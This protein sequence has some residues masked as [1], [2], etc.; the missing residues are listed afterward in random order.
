[1][2][3]KDFIFIVAVIAMSVC[4]VIGYIGLTLIFASVAI[5]ALAAGLLE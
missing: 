5:F 1:M 4:A 2:T 3:F